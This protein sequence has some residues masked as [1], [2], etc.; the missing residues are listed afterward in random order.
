M[1]VKLTKGMEVSLAEAK[2]GEGQKGIWMMIPIKAEKGFD[3]INCWV[4]NAEE[5]RYYTGTAKIKEILDV[6]ITNTQSKDKTKW[7][8]QYGVSVILD[9]K[10]GN[11]EKVNKGLSAFDE[12]LQIP[13]DDSL[14]FN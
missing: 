5:A 9:G 8:Q 10:N 4:A 3:R 14:P 1:A 2:S 6:S 11:R 12:F 13:E 7:Y